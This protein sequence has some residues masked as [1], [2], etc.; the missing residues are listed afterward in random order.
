MNNETANKANEEGDPNLSESTE[1]PA[2]SEAEDSGVDD[3][4]MRLEREA[5]D[6]KDQLLRALAEAENTRRRAERDVAD[7]RRYAVTSFARDMLSV[8]DNFN[9]ALKSVP[10]GQIAEDPN[11]KALLEGIEMTERELLNTLQ[12]HGIV[13]DDPEG[14]RFDPNKHEALFEVPNESVPNMTIVQVVEPGYLIG[15][16]VLRPAKVGVSKGGPKPGA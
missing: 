16:R 15:E 12:K 9:R 4:V 6:L 1:A 8:S 13:K 10:E 3:P 5:A 14:E 2:T 7:A 11:V